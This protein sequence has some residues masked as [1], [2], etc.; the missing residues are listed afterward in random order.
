MHVYGRHAALARRNPPNK[1]V[2]LLFFA[3]MQASLCRN[4]RH[5][6]INSAETGICVCAPFFT[7][8]NSAQ[9]ARQTLGLSQRCTWDALCMRHAKLGNSSS[10]NVDVMQNDVA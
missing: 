4:C 3:G 7:I 2:Y 10:D 6:P 8:A 5:S 1:T 9:F